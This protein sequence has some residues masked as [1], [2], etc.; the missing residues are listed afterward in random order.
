MQSLV[1]FLPL[2]GNVPRTRVLLSKEEL[3]VTDQAVALWPPWETGPSPAPPPPVCWRFLRANDHLVAP[4]CECLIIHEGPCSVNRKRVTSQM[5]SQGQCRN[6]KEIKGT[7][8]GQG[9]PIPTGS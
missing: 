8:R 1:L 2:F 4:R 9:R 5:Y 7:K 6:T 3:R